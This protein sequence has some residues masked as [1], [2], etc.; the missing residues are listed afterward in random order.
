MILLDPRKSNPGL[1]KF[2]PTDPDTSFRLACQRF[3]CFCFTKR[4][5]LEKSS[6][7]ARHGWRFRVPSPVTPLLR[8][9]PHRFFQRHSGPPRDM[10]EPPYLHALLPGRVHCMMTFSQLLRLLILCPKCASVGVFNSSVDYLVSPFF[11]KSCFP[12]SIRL[13]PTGRPP[14]PRQPSPFPS[15]SFCPFLTGVC[16][17]HL[18]ENFGI[19]DACIGELNSI[20]DIN[21]NT[22]IY[23]V[24][25]HVHCGKKRKRLLYLETKRWILSSPPNFLISVPQKFSWRIF[26]RRGCPWCRNIVK[27]VFVLILP[28]GRQTFGSPL[29]NSLT[30]LVIPVDGCRGGSRFQRWDNSPPPPFLS[31]VQYI[32]DFLFF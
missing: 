2:G 25:A 29:K 21:R 24:L 20:L 10:V 17:Y 5:L 14:P 18:W 19:K 11:L 28:F 32:F 22:F 27:L 7:Q 3:H 9:D 8:C 12:S 6:L 4:L 26:P 13:S 1:W 31:S 30:Y 23:Q 15:F 16:G